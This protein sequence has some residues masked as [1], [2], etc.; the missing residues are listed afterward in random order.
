MCVLT[1]A[2]VATAVL[3]VVLPVPAAVVPMLPAIAVA[4]ALM[5][6]WVVRGG[7]VVGVVLGVV[8]FGN[9]VVAKWSQLR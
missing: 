5:I 9:G 3:V 6:S 8:A 7:A 4:T 1:G 2:V